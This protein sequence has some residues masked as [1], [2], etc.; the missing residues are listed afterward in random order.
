MFMFILPN[1]LADCYKE[2]C[3]ILDQCMS[4]LPNTLGGG[5][6]AE[7]VPVIAGQ[8]P[9]SHCR[10]SCRIQ[11]HKLSISACE[12]FNLDCQLVCMGEVA[13]FIQLHD[14]RVT[15]IES[16]RRCIDCYAIHSFILLSIGL[17]LH[18]FKQCRR[19]HHLTRD[20]IYK[21]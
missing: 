12:V 11:D 3:F 5:P 4:K 13:F 19:T 8:T 6:G 18:A 21:K 10:C 9:L 20:E 16:Y 7:I 14:Q 1:V 2:T 17:K 15:I